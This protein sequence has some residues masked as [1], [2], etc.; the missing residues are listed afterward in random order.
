M[1]IIRITFIRNVRSPVKNVAQQDVR[2]IKIIKTFLRVQSTVHSFSF[3][4]Y[5][6]MLCAPCTL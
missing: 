5:G 3:I 2:S 6:S 4:K 1:P